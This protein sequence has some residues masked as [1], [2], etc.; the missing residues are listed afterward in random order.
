MRAG[1]FRESVPIDLFHRIGVGR[2]DDD[3]LMNIS[4][5]WGGFPVIESNRKNSEFDRVLET[6]VDPK[7]QLV[8]VLIILVRCQV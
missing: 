2:S 6:F 1:W 3:E 5:S 4:L 8:S 7:L